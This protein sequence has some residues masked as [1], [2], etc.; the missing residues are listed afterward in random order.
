MTKAEMIDEIDAAI[1][2]LTK[3]KALL[4]GNEMSNQLLGPQTPGRRPISAEGRRKIADAQR[5]RWVKVK[6]AMRSV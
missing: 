6:A 4:Q 1:S 3:V 5:A 2:R